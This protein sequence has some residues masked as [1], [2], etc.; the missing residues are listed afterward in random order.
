MYRCFC[1]I[2]LFTMSVV[3]CAGGQDVHGN[4]GASTRLPLLPAEVMQTTLYPVRGEVRVEVSLPDTVD[5]NAAKVEASLCESGT[6][7]VLNKEQV[8]LETSRTAICCLSVSP[9]PEGRYDIIATVL[10]REGNAVAWVTQPVEIPGKPA[11]LGSREGLCEGLPPGWA[12]IAVQGNTVR[13]WGRRYLFDGLP[14]PVE[15]IAA[16]RNILTGPVRFWARV[17]GAQVTWTP[18]ETKVEQVNEGIVKVT[19]S[20]DS[21]SLTLAATMT[22]ECDGMIRSDWEI[23]PKGAVTLEYLGIEI[24]LATQHARYLYTFPG[25]WGSAYNAGAAPKEATNMAFRPFIWLGDEERGFCWFSESDRNFSV[26]DTEQVTQIIPGTEETVLRINMISVPTSLEK[27]LD[28]T[29]G[30]QATPVRDNPQD[31]WDFRICHH[32]NYGIEDTPYSRAAEVVYPAKDCINPAAGTVEAR[33]RVGFDP[34]TEIKDPEKRG[35]LNREFFTLRSSD[36]TDKFGFY[37]NID[38]RGMRAYLKQGDG[39]PV[40]VGTRAEWK[41]GEWHHVAVTWGDGMMAVW[42]DGQKAGETS[43]NGTITPAPEK[44]EMLFQCLPGHFDLDE[45]RISD[46]ARTSFDL[47]GPAE[48][49]ASTLL[50]DHFE[51]LNPL[52]VYTQPEKGPAGALSGAKG[53]DGPYGVCLI[54]S[55]PG[56]AFTTLDRLAE[57]GVRTICFHEHW[58]DIQNYATTTHGPELTKLVN[59]C[60]ERNIRLIPYFGY[61]LSDIA[62][63]WKYYSEECLVAPRAGG[64]H[65]L[66]EQHAYIV[67]YESAWQDYLA[68]GIAKAMDTY[69]LDGVY[70]DGTANPWKC[71]NTWHGC[72][73]L[74]PDGTIGDTYPIF[75]TREMMKR[76]WTIVKSRKPDGMINVHQSTTMTIPT[77]AFATSYWDGE[78]LGGI[79]RGQWSLD[80]LPLDAFRCE[81]MGHQWGVPAELLCYE[82]PYTYSEAMSFSLLHDVLVR[83][84]L[85]GNLEMESKLWHAMDAFGRQQATWLPYWR[86]Q[87][88]VT[89]DS[90][91][92]KVSLYSRGAM[93]LVMILSNLGK[94]AREVQARLNLQ[95]LQLGGALTALDIITEEE[96]AVPADG[97]ITQE[98][99]PLEFCVLWIRPAGSN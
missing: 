12:P 24:P 70:L 93:G 53:A 78:Q 48:A 15:V 95:A 81:F 64:Y 36:S 27:A 59:A 84:T 21:E 14:A 25:S 39:Y 13:P 99:D 56:E 22:V 62:P 86:N 20:C 17:E 32:G 46:I 97:V 16:A 29:F 75:A 11:W 65:R 74:R 42:Y 92:T 41:Q 79:P 89:T 45:I 34:N 4:T 47:A 61:E 66:P 68:D 23:I 49:D 58:T 98:L 94:D 3:L 2:L 44:A 7:L 19:A 38:D 30:F 91:D 10:D 5:N 83:G 87:D 28:Y 67:C 55:H 50:L 52:L 8:T 85:G 90:N 82:Q 96:S 35:Q 80:L 40:M 54:S 43:W 63:E 9:F 26:S 71:R 37:W 57:L 77:L 18:K 1:L 60:H 33:V 88:A 31:V 51:G 69:D 6:G 72:G 73:Y 76:I